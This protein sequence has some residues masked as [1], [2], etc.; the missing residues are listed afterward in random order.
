MKTGGGHTVGFTP[1]EL[2]DHLSQ[3][4]IRKWVYER[5]RGIRRA[6]KAPLQPWEKRY[7]K[8]RLSEKELEFVSG[9]RKPP[10]EEFRPTPSVAPYHDPLEVLSDEEDEDTSILEEYSHEIKM[11]TLFALLIVSITF[12]ILTL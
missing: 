1:D 6:L 2:D 8:S 4:Q 9:E 10:T 11:T 7:I 5:R 12:F 3:H